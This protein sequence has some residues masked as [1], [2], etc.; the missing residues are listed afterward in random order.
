MR[1]VLRYV[2]AS[3]MVPFVWTVDHFMSYIAEVDAIPWSQLWR[4][5]T[6]PGLGIYDS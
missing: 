6:S 4:E 3:F 5:W 2:V 1:V